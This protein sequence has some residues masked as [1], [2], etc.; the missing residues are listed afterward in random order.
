MADP[1]PTASSPATSLIPSEPRLAGLTEQWISFVNTIVDRTLIRTYLFAY[2]KAMMTCEL[3]DRLAI[4]SI[5]PDMGKPIGILD[6]AVAKSGYLVGDQL[7]LADLNL[8]PIFDRVILAPEGAEALAATAHLSLFREAR[9]PAEFSAHLINCRSARARKTNAR[10]SVRS[11]AVASYHVEAHGR[12]Q[13][14]SA[15]AKQ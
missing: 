12:P 3:P 10:R 5:L 11:K 6:N 14:H 1:L 15:T 4:D 2:I 9:C 7:T 13:H 8:L